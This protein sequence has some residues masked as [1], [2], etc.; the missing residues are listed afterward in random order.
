MFDAA[1]AE[2]FL[3]INAIITGGVFSAGFVYVIDGNSVSRIFRSGS[4]RET[5]TPVKTIFSQELVL[6]KKKSCEFKLKSDQ[7]C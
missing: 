4:A 5:P 7:S 2:Q 3:I 6:L 1:L